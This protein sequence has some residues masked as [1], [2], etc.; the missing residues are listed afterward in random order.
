LSQVLLMLENSF[1]EVLNWH[2][3][4]LYHVYILF[5]GHPSIQSFPL[6]I[7]KSDKQVSCMSCV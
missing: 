4:V 6:I 1:T 2:R 5:L 7:D 3:F